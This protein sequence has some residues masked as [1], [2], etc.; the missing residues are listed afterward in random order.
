VR[1]ARSG[2]RSR[3]LPTAA[4]A[5]PL[6]VTLLVLLAW[7]ETRREIHALLSLGEVAAD[8]DIE[9]IGFRAH[10]RQKTGPM[11]LGTSLRLGRGARRRT[12]PLPISHAARDEIA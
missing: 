8:I 11:S 7:P 12:P 6:S 1:R 5:V 10:R 9:L 2:R 4:I 3:R